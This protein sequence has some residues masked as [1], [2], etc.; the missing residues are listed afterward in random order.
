MGVVAVYALNDEF[1]TIL[2]ETKNGMVSPLSYVLAKTILVIPIM[3]V[4]GVFALGIPTFAIMDFPGSAFGMGL[5][6]WSLTMYAFECVAESLSVWFEDPILG[7]FQFTN[8]WFGSLL[9]AGVVIP[10]RDMFWPFELFYHV[11]PVS[12]YVRSQLYNLIHDTTWEI[13]IKAENPNSPVCAFPPSGTNVLEEMSRVYVVESD[14]NIAQ[15]L[16][17]LAGIAFFWK[18][19]YIAGVVYRSSQVSKIH[20]K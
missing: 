4:F 12:Y 8:Y 18:L 17:G 13:C 16:A 6:W 7:M 3:F 14:G 5:L 11:F 19:T 20:E 9:F 15:D 2:R 10:K 1:K